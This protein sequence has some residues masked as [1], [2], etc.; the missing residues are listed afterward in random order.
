MSTLR[1]LLMQN[2]RNIDT[3]DIHAEDVLELTLTISPDWIGLPTLISMANIVGKINDAGFELLDSDESEKIAG[4][5]NS[6]YIPT[7]QDMWRDRS[8]QLQAM[9]V[10]S[11]NAHFYGESGEISQ[12]RQIILHTAHEVVS[13]KNTDSIRVA[14]DEMV[15]KIKVRVQNKP[16]WWSKLPALLLKTAVTTVFDSVIGFPLRTLVTHVLNGFFDQK[17]KDQNNNY[18]GG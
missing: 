3:L 4:L 10:S 12:V 9:P 7:S 18:Q 15:E 16:G 5:I 17:N 6:Y 14:Q 11:E 1:I 13:L 8:L 2:G